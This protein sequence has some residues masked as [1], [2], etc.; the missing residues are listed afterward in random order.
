[1]AFGMTGDLGILKE[2]TALKK[3][4]PFRLLVDDA[5]G[6]G[7]MG[8]DGSGTGTHL[9]CQD[10]IDIYFGTFAKA[11]A[12]IGAFVASEPRVIEF[13]KANTRSQIFAKSVPMP[14]VKTARKRL[15]M[16]QD[17]PEWREKLWDNTIKLR[18]GLREIGYNV[19]PAE[20]P[21]TPVLTQG[22]TEL[23]STIMYKMREE[24][25]IFVSGV[26]YPVVPKGTVLI[27]LIPTAS[28][29]DEH[30]EKTLDG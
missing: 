11:F 3:D 7:T 8:E 21:V 20:C 9:G 27:R 13:L 30:I 17:H 25:G 19:L 14:I 23:C 10:E 12:L 24:H 5:H 28:H 15:E 22:S 4:Y 6:L 2:M 29:T 16:I 18:K 1:G 26:T